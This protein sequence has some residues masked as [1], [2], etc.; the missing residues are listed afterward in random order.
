M[1]KKIRLLCFFL[2]IGI[3]ISCF[4]FLFKDK[5]SYFVYN[6][7]SKENYNIEYSEEV[8]KASEE[9]GVEESVI[10]AVIKTESNFDKDAVSRV[11]AIG[12]MQLMPETYLW[13][14]TRLGEKCDEEMITDPLTN[15]RYGTYYL[16][17]LYER[18][19]DEKAVFASY[20]AG[21]T[22]VKGWLADNRYSS[23]G[24]NLTNIPYP[25]TSSYVKKVSK[26]LNV[27]KELLAESNKN[28]S[29]ISSK[30]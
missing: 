25:E 20:N 3:S 14:A 30:D 22:R 2:V 23:D 10:Y 1:T 26:A 16:K 12:L 7:M 27:Y 29:F 19:E 6:F 4:L 8:K 24:K 5:I 11:G 15:I 17:F 21:Y 18:L 9:F 28:S 13:I